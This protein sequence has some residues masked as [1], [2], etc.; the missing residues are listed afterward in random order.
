MNRIEPAG[1]DVI[2]VIVRDHMVQHC[3]CGYHSDVPEEH[4]PSAFTPRPCE[5]RRKVEHASKHFAL[6][7]VTRERGPLITN[8]DQG[9]VLALPPGTTAQEL[10]DFRAYQRDKK[11]YEKTRKLPAKSDQSDMVVS[12]ESAGPGGKP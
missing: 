1:N 10:A 9:V 7:A 3:T 6:H 11:E 2:G 12:G 4:G 5:W 8:N